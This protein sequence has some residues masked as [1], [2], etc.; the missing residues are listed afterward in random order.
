MFGLRKKEAKDE[1]VAHRLVFQSIPEVLNKRFDKYGVVFEDDGE[2]IWLYATN[3][4]FNKVYCAIAIG[5]SGC[6]DGKET[7]IVHNAFHEKI[8]I[9]IDDGFQ[10]GISFRDKK[11]LSKNHKCVGSEHWGR[12]VALPWNEDFFTCIAP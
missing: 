1:T 7:F 9:Y 2:S 6:L 8:G 5:L 4:S 10:A 12:D 11:C 3:A